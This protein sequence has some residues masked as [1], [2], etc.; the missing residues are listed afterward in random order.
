MLSLT[1][2]S[3]LALISEAEARPREAQNAQV[4]DHIW[5]S[6]QPVSVRHVFGRPCASQCRNKQLSDG[7]NWVE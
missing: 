7:N 4:A 1:G 3:A 2:V 5:I 6:K